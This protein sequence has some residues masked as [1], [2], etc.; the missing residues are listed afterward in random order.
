MHQRLPQTNW[1]FPAMRHQPHRNLLF[2]MPLIVTL[3]LV[4]LWLLVGTV[5]GTLE[6]EDT[7]P[8][9]SLVASGCCLVAVWQLVRRI[10]AVARM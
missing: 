7:F 3:L 2:V 8:L 10:Q 9:F 6:G 4:Q 1:H 5:E